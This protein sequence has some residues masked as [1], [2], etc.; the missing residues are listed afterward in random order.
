MIYEFLHIDVNMLDVI[1]WASIGCVVGYYWGGCDKA[2]EIDDEK[3]LDEVV[4]R[5]KERRRDWEDRH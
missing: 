3:L 2:G 1:L 4:S 5:R